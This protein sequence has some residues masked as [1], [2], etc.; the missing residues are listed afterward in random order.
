MSGVPSPHAGQPRLTTQGMISAIGFVEAP[1]GNLTPLAFRFLHSLF[2]AVSPLPARLAALEEQ[3]AALQAEVR[4][5]QQRLP[6]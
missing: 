3:A 1:T 2:A 6:P 4:A 5:L